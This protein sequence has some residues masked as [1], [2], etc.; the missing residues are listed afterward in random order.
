MLEERGV[1]G[2]GLVTRR[3][4]IDI[5]LPLVY[6]HLQIVI[7]IQEGGELMPYEKLPKV[8]CYDCVNRHHLVAACP[9]CETGVVVTTCPED[10]NGIAEAECNDC[11]AAVGFYVVMKERKAWLLAEPVQVVGGKEKKSGRK[12][13]E[14]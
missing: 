8:V 5:S 2:K 6:N 1:F 10:F 3:I 13:P 9:K 12:S 4:C 11:K 7:K 14:Q